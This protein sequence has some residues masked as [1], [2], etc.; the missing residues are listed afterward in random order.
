MCLC[1]LPPLKD[2]ALAFISLTVIENLFTSSFV[3]VFTF[4]QVIVILRFAKIERIKVHP[5]TYL[6]PN[7]LN[8]EVDSASSNDNATFGSSKR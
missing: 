6:S 7:G 4:P 5:H 8:L 3:N 2:P 1:L